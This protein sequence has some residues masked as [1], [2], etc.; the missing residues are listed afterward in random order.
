MKYQ[1]N[2]TPNFTVDQCDMWNLMLVGNRWSCPNYLWNVRDVC[3][4]SVH[5]TR[6]NYGRER[7]VKW[8]AKM[9]PKWDQLS[10][11]TP[12]TLLCFIAYPANGRRLYGTRHADNTAFYSD[13]FLRKHYTCLGIVKI[14][15][16][17]FLCMY[18]T[19]VWL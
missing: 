13:I 11:W 16:V 15:S 5:I 14:R 10:G 17:P 4:T 9:A 19:A 8:S 7:D 18:C 12:S 1:R 6:V 2:P 3:V